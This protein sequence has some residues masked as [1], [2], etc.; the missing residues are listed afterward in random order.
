MKAGSPGAPWSLQPTPIRNKLKERSAELFTRMAGE[1]GTQ[2]V[3]ESFLLASTSA[4]GDSAWLV[5]PQRLV[6]FRVVEDLGS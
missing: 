6:W 4:F 5:P 1:R 3:W 2:Q